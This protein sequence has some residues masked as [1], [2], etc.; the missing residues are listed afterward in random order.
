[1]KKYLFLIVCF[2]ACYFIDNAQS[3]IHFTNDSMIKYAVFEENNYRGISPESFFSIFL[4]LDNSNQFIAIDTVYSPDSAYTY[5]KY[6]QTYNEYL[7]ENT[8]V[9]LTIHNNS[10]IRF[11][12]NYETINELPTINQYNHED[13]ISKYQSYY[14]DYEHTD[15]YIISSVI[16]KDNF[17]NLCLCYKIHQ[18]STNVLLYISASDLSVI[19]EDYFAGA[20]FNATFFTQYNGVRQG[21]NT[22]VLWGSDSAFILRDYDAAIDIL[23]VEPNVTDLSSCINTFYNNSSVWGQDTNGIYPNYMLD[24]YWSA[25]EYVYYLRNRFNCPKGYFQRNYTNL[26]YYI[27]DTLTPIYIASNTFLDNTHWTQVLCENMLYSKDVPPQPVPIY[28]NAIV[29]GSQGTTHNAR[30]S[31]DEVVHEYAHIFS[32]QSW[33]PF[34]STQP[35]HNIKDNR[36]AEACA[37]IWSAII[38]HNVYPDNEDKIWKIGEDVVLPTSGHTCIR[39]LSNPTD[40]NAEIFMNEN[41]CQEVSGQAYQQSGIISHW[42]YLLSHGFSDIGCDGT[43]YSFPAL[44]IDSISKLLYYCERS[45][46]FHD[47]EYSDI[48]QA[49]LDAAEIFQNPEEMKISILQAWKVVGVEP[50]SI[51]GV[52]QFGLSYNSSN[53]SI[54]TINTDLIVDSLQT[55]LIFGILNISDSARI[56][57]RP[58]GKL[59]VDGGTLTTAC[60]AEMWPGITVLGHPDKRQIAQN[61][62]SVELRNGAVIEHARCGIILGADENDTLH[63][64]GILSATDAS[65]RNCARAI[66]FRPYA[67]SEIALIGRWL[68]RHWSGRCD[69]FPQSHADA[70]Y[71]GQ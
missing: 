36:L 54:Y 51:N 42:F 66:N 59:V 41:T 20:G 14:N 47:M 7:V 29:I 9:R 32:F 39:N 16:T 23:K 13:I 22:G 19:K 15:G 38:T 63:T 69:G 34:F 71:S 67:Y 11:C 12:G 27:C 40:T 31:I 37:D 4:E 10:I 33:H 70:V 52:E 46:F 2:L 24:A 60:D 45:H 30:S 48:C 57:V 68:R 64:G 17:G 26:G 65:F 1:M 49:T 58:G 18:I 6:V 28:R 62:G 50:E 56:I 3:I 25:S 55:L 61:Q 5:I 44:P 53:N 8:L 21:F 35:N 43:C